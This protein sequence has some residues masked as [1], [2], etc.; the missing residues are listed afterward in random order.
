MYRQQLQD[1]QSSMRQPG[2]PTSLIETKREAKLNLEKW[3]NV[4]ESIMRQK[5]RVQWLKLGDGN[6]TYFHARL[7]N[8]LAQNR[9]A[10]LTNASGNIVTSTNDVEADILGFYKKLVGTCATQLPAVNCQAM[11]DGPR[12][13]RGHKGELTSVKQVDEIFKVFS[14]ASELEANVDKSSIYFGGV[15]TEMQLAIMQELD[16]S[17]GVPINER[18]IPKSRME[19]ADMQYL[20]ISKM[21]FYLILNIE[22]EA[23][24]KGKA[25]Y[26]GPGLAKGFKMTSY[27]KAD[28]RME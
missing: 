6:T 3:L 4:E 19:E 1:I 23:P 13:D 9:I 7:R 22:W 12:L 5:S 15:P 20:C 21:E 28:I 8:R 11:K 10:S 16:F 17:Q 24:D 26:L 18:G 25:T 14:A 27:Q 2:Q